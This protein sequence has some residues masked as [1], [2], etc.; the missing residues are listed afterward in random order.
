MKKIHLRTVD[1]N[2]VVIGIRMAQNIGCD[3]L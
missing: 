3:C 2:V 1:T